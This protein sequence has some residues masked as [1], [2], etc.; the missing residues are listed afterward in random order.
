MSSSFY[1]THTHTWHYLHRP[2]RVKAECELVAKGEIEGTP[3]IYAIP[4]TYESLHV[5][6]RHPS[7]GCQSTLFFVNRMVIVRPFCVTALVLRSALLLFLST[8]C[9]RFYIVFYGLC[10]CG[11]VCWYWCLRLFAICHGYP[12]RRTA[13]I[14][15]C[16]G[17]QRSVGSILLTRS[18]NLFQPLAFLCLLHFAFSF[19]S[20]FCFSPNDFFQFLYFYICSGN[21][22]LEI[23][24][25]ECTNPH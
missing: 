7:I 3:R 11:C 9:V 1:N 12:R 4:V 17:V 14:Q 24:L 19:V 25:A 2:V 6:A 18:H 22:Q 21:C 16:I 5:S 10:V 23:S 20:L 15:S 13:G 8:F